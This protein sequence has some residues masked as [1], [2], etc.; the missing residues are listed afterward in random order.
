MN[1]PQKPVL[2]VAILCNGS[3]FEAWEAAC[4]REVMALPFTEIVLRIAPPEQE[5]P[6]R[7]FVHKLLNY[8][9][10]L[11]L[12]NRLDKKSK[13]IPARRPVDMNSELA[14]AP[15]LHC[16]PEKKGKYS[17][18]FTETDIETIR[19]YKPDMILRFGYNIIRGEILNVAP[20]GVWSFHHA[21]EQVIRGGPGAF[22]EI[23]HGH[24]VTGALLQRLTGKLDAGIVLRKG[25]FPTVRH[26]YLHNLDQLL[27]GTTSWM[28]Q[29][30]N[31]IHHNQASYFTA[32][33]LETKAPVYRF[34]RNGTM[35]HFA[36]KL[37]GQKIRFHYRELFCAE[38]WN[39]GIIRKPISALLHGELPAEVEW[40]AEAAGKNFK[41]DPF[42][43]TDAQG[44][45]HVLYER[46]DF[47]TGKG[48][49]EMQVNGNAATL[50]E[51]DFHLSFPF[52]F[53]HEGKRY[54]LPEAN[55][56]GKLTCYEL[57]GNAVK[58]VRDLLPVPA[59]DA[60]IVFYE[61]RWWL[62]CTDEFE[63]S[64]HKLFI[65][66]SAHP[67]GPWEAHVNNPVKCDIRSARPAGAAFVHEGKLY[68]PAQCCVPE[69]GS[70]L[71]LHEV[72]ELTITGFREVAVKRL[73]P[74]PH[75]KYVH[76]LHHVSAPCDDAMLID[77]KYYRFS[78]SHFLN[79]LKRKRRRLL[80]K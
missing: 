41:A 22:W 49:I 63:G 35:L 13:K 53:T 44:N 36:F 11:L 56:S 43:F 68:R 79:V 15:L 62:F 46:Y 54:L 24:D 52:V 71:I 80:N 72:V 37:L 47:N 42:G 10:K 33:P 23:M 28:K 20:Y 39:V 77:A 32:P 48:V 17:E 4:I 27:W 67:L 9:W 29:V 2:R 1:Q 3:V 55:A 58:P 34:P 6:A 75:W 7:G 12:W 25:W 59:V 76:G 19:S 51:T 8:S 38:Q 66:H 14:A 60:N 61:N 31:D 65:Y 40:L 78:F 70:A 45:E 5:L 64:N 18:Y 57:D 50:L 26:A 21:D 30:C 16:L 74:N 69:Y 73:N